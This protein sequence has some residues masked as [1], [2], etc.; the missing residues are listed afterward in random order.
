MKCTYCDAQD[1]LETRCPSRAGDRRKEVGLGIVVFFLSFIP[2]IIGLL[3]GMWWSALKTGFVFTMDFWPSA[4]ATIRGKKD[5]G[6]S[7]TV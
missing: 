5:D 6:E 7:G 1:H 4:W 2:Y 3:A